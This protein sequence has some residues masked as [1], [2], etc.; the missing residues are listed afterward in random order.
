MSTP[1]AKRRRYVCKSSICPFYK[2]TE[3]QCIFCDGDEFSSLRISFPDSKSRKAYMDTYC[4]KDYESCQVFK[5]F[6][7][8]K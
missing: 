1:A 6:N 8:I 3:P 4:D 7:Q 5:I 2:A